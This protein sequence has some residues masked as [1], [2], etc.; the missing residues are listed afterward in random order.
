MSKKLYE[1]IS[2]IVGSKFTLKGVELTLERVTVSKLIELELQGQDIQTLMNGFA[3]TPATVSTKLGWLLLD[4]AS[5][6][7]FDNKYTTFI[8][9]LD[10]Q[11][12]EA[13]SNAVI[14]AV[15]NSKPTEQNEK[16]EQGA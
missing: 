9:L 14:E 3:E 4:D 7:S 15:N 12:L 8:K 16:N 2:N 5:K 1:L 10:M 13:L 6:E 11:D